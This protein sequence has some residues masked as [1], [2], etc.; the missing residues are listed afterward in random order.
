MVPGLLNW[1]SV[2]PPS[3]AGFTR[4]PRSEIEAWD[5]TPQTSNKAWPRQMVPVRRPRP[6]PRS[7]AASESAV[8]PSDFFDQMRAH[9]R[10]Q[11]VRSPGPSTQ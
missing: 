10:G 8:W 9:G 2:R 5:V 3:K 4:Y 1:D 11:L 7:A 6:L